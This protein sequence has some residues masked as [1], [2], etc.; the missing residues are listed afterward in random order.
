[1]KLCAAFLLCLA[2]VPL[3]A[4]AQNRSARLLRD[5]YGV[6][7]AIG[8][9]AGDTLALEEAAFFGAGYAAARDRLLQMVLARASVQ[10][11]LAEILGARATAQDRRMRILGLYQQARYCA[12]QLGDT[13]RRLLDAYARGVNEYMGT[14]PQHISNLA[15]STA[16]IPEPWT[17]ADG[18]ACFLR[19][20]EFFDRGWAGEVQAQKTFE[21]M[22]GSKTRE[23]AI[24]ELE[25]GRR[26]VDDSA[27][28]VTRDEYQRYNEEFGKLFTG[29]GGHASFHK[30]S[31]VTEEWE[32]PKMSHN[33]VLAASRSSSGYPVLE[34]DPQIAVQSPATWYEH[35]IAGGRYNVRGISLPGTPVMLL[36]F[37]AHCGWGLTALGSDNA[38]LFQEQPK[39][40]SSTEYAWQGGWETMSERVETIHVLGGQDVT[41]TVRG[42][43]HGPVVNDLLTGV[44]SGDVFALQWLVLKEPA[45]TIEGLLKMMAARDWP[46][47]VKGVEMYQSPGTHLIY[48]DRN[49]TIAYYTMARIPL[50][51]HDAGIPYRGWTG[52]EEW[53]GV[54][55]FAEMPRMLNPRAGF[56]STANNAP[57]GSWYPY[58]I[59]G[60]L[61]DNARSARLKEL[62]EGGGMLDPADVLAIHTDMVEPIARDFARFAIM[63]VDAEKPN[64]RDAV[65]GADSL[66]GWDYRHNTSASVYRMTSI[67]GTTIKRTLRGTPLEQRYL[68]SDA[69]LIQ[70]FRDLEK[71]ETEH[72]GLMPDAD[73][74]AWLIT[75]LADVYRRSGIARAGGAGVT[76]THAMPWQ[77]NLEKLGSMN[78]AYDRVSPPLTCPV[79]ATI[80][81]QTGNSYSQFIDFAQVDSSLS[82]LPPGNSELPRSSHF[83]DMVPLWVAGGMHPA[84]LSLPA[85]DVLKEDEL[86]VYD[87]PDGIE[88]TA[89]GEDVTLGAAYP[90][91]TSGV[92]LVPV[93]VAA[94]AQITLDVRDVL[95]RVVARE[96]VGHRQPGRHTLTWFPH[97]D[98]PAGM[99]VVTISTSTTQRS[100][101]VQVQR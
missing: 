40:G 35:H 97:N 75:Q 46:S 65:A 52:D 26:Q 8:A 54:V 58:A 38:D 98:L 82:I 85:L 81:S 68:G 96:S 60:G 95:G 100:T 25:A 83:D 42:T 17:P 94:G 28:I 92:V 6:T 73:I 30:G 93:E 33:W 72:G 37:N 22:L 34:A 53:R 88:G 20:A 79:V 36:G 14:H 15:L 70:L 87:T 80:W 84:P 10:G 5:R 29:S 32:P 47:F 55:P 4:D 1:M 27:A 90:N 41:F 50:R 43:R 44:D 74:R 57:V 51:V 19:I 77:D 7:H 56:I 101:G 11:R 48:A 2:I 62:L 64:N 69:G 16:I 91:P 18:I 86:I 31:D 21:A 99:Y 12:T 3:T 66:R 67:I 61:G 13:A 76:V 71:Y 63:A 39:P 24:A 9:A 89:R 45:T 78:P 23:Q 49:K 59:G